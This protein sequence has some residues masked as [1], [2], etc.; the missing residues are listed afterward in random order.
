MRWLYS[1]TGSMNM[2][3]KKLWELVKDREAWHAAMQRVRLDLVIEQQIHG[4]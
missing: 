2:D 1:V 3:L 4:K